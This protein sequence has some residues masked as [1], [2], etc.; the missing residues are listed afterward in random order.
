M[1]MRM[2]FHLVQYT[3]FVFAGILIGYGMAGFGGL[4]LL[5]GSVIGLVNSK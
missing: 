2:A 3:L 5:I 4:A 1:S